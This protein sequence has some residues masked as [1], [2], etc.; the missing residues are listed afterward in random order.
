MPK[1][2]VTATTMAHATKARPDM[3]QTRATAI[4]SVPQ[5]SGRFPIPAATEAEG[6]AYGN[7]AVRSRIDHRPKARVRI[8]A[9]IQ[10]LCFSRAAYAVTLRA[11][12]T[13][14][15]TPP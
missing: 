14:R 2:P 11:T 3:A 7:V 15:A 4:T 1:H 6:L 5:K 9:R 10:L 8:N 12:K 13:T